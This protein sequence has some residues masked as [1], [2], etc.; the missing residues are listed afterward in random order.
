MAEWVVFK[1]ETWRGG[2]PLPVYYAGYQAASWAD[3]GPIFNRTITS[4][5]R[6]DEKTAD[7][8]IKQLTEMGHDV[9]KRKIAERKLRAK[10]S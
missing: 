4:K 5:A 2:N 3:C 8:A 1:M 10:T 9:K 6:F 7:M